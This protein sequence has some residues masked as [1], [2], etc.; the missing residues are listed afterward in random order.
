[1]PQHQDQCLSHKC[2]T[3]KSFALYKSLA[4]SCVSCSA[5]LFDL[6]SLFLAVFGHSTNF[7]LSSAV[8]CLTQELTD[9]ALSSRFID[10]RCLFHVVHRR[11]VSR[12]PLSHKILSRHS[13]G[14][15]L[16]THP[17]TSL[18]YPRILICFSD[19]SVLAHPKLATRVT[20]EMEK[21]KFHTQRNARP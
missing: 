16:A 4:T 15:D 13:R 17:C 9:S 3:F 7:I 14:T 18:S 1:M 10:Q 6:F 11:C 12:I 2:A 21:D 5:S 19:G 20:T 8:S